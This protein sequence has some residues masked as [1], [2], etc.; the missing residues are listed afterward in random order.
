MAQQRH[1]GGRTTIFRLVQVRV[2]ALRLCPAEGGGACQD[3]H[4]IPADAEGRE[5]QPRSREGENRSRQGG[6]RQVAM[7]GLADRLAGASLS[8]R[9]RR[10]TRAAGGERPPK[11][12]EASSRSSSPST[13]DAALS[14][15]S[16][17]V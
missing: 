15:A 6:H 14:M 1:E 17:R 7:A 10:Q 3:C 16:Q 8:A 13:T 11:Q 4:R 12:K 2:L 9:R 5:L